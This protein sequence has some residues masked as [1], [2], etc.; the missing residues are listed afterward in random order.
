MTSSLKG[1]THTDDVSRWYTFKTPYEWYHGMSRESIRKL[2]SRS[3][4]I[5]GRKIPVC[6]WGSGVRC[7]S[8]SL[9]R[10]GK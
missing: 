8:F 10:T 9:E 6:H 1:H 5:T 4:I 7:R 2:N 3:Y